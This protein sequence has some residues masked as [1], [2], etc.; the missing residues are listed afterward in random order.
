MLD[1]YICND[2]IKEVIY[3]LDNI[4]HNAY[5]VNMAIAWAVSVAYVKYPTI[6]M[7]YLKNNTLDDFTYNKALQKICE[8]YRVSDEDKSAIRRM[9]RK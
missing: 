3:L 1:F 9:K 4:K 2:Y 8:S 7:E 6:T 5:Y